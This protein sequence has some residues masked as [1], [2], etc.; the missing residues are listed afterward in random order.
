LPPTAS[1]GA[2]QTREVTEGKLVEGEVS[3]NSPDLAGTGFGWT[4]P[5]ALVAP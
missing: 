4:T 2:V 3:L 1:P 5:L